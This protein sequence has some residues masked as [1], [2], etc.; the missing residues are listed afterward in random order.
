MKASTIRQLVESLG[1][2]AAAARVLGV[3][4]VSVKGWV[5]GKRGMSDDMRNKVKAAT[6]R[7]LETIRRLEKAL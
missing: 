2:N 3:P 6:R 7:H 1:G 4:Q 5:Y